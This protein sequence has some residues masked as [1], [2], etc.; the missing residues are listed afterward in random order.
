MR[1][2]ASLACQ[3]VP[4]GRDRSQAAA[5]ATF[6][7]PKLRL[8]DRFDHGWS[9]AALQDNFRIARNP[10]GIGSDDQIATASLNVF[11]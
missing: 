8:R 6:Q 5:N 1:A 4:C 2:A 7:L 11:E 10:T 3:R 9:K